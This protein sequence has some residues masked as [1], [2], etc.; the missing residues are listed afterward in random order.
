MS[1]CGP[2][3]NAPSTRNASY[4]PGGRPLLRRGMLLARETIVPDAVKLGERPVER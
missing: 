4:N 3:W 2:D 1:H